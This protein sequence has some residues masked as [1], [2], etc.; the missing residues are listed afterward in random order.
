[1]AASRSCRIR[2]TR[3]RHRCS[4][5]SRLRCRT[6]RASPGRWSRRGWLEHGPAGAGPA[7]RPRRICAG[8][9]AAGA[10]SRRRGIAAGLRATWAERRVRRLLWLGQRRSLSRCAA[11][12]PS[13][14]EPRRRLCPL[15]Q[16]L[17]L[18]CR[19]GDP[20]ARHRAAGDRRRQQCQLGRTG[21]GERA[22]AGLWRDGAQKQ[23]CRRRR[24]QPARRRRESARGARA[25][26][27]IPPDR[28]VAR[29]P[30][31]G[32][33]RGVALDPPGNRCRADARDRP[34]AGGRRPPR[35]RLSRPLLRRL[36]EVRGLS[37]RPEGWPAEGCRLGRG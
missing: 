20:A 18:G 21:R 30:A 37:A 1:M 16:Q 25:R 35:P 5:T 14:F 13:L 24:H 19:D 33:G 10:R 34:H 4:A 31:G 11:P 6:A 7:A 2:A 28:P 23:R 26:R 32:S 29:R 12:D 9:V 15:G 17:Q 36:A 22:G 27:R 8:V 3:R